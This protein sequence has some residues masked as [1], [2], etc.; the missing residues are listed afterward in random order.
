MMQ[1]LHSIYITEQNT[2]STRG[3]GLICIIEQ[4][5][6]HPERDALSVPLV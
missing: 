4:V 2:E 6:T 1:A 3:R 5:L